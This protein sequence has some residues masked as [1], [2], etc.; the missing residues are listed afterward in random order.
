[1]YQNKGHSYLDKIKRNSIHLSEFADTK[2]GIIVGDEKRYI[3]NSAL[4][5]KHK[6]VLRGRDIGRYAV[7]WDNNFVYYD[8]EVLTRAREQHIFEC[9]KKILTQHVSGK[10]IAALDEERYY[11][12]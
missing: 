10:I 2:Q 6:K 9:E 5:S 11:A 3:T 7:H 8:R 12:L 4:S 1:M